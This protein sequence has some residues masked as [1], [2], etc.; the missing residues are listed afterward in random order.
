MPGFVLINF[1]FMLRIDIKQICKLILQTFYFLFLHIIKT[2]SKILLFNKQFQKAIFAL[3]DFQ[4]ISPFVIYLAL[5][6]K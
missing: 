2:S 6:F 4:T 1:F 3:K 5:L